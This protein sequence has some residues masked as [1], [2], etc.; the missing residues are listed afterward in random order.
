M[1]DQIKQAV[2]D[3]LNEW[4]VSISSALVGETVRDN[5]WTCDEWRVS[6]SR[7]AH[8]ERLPGT[9][10]FD[11]SY[12]TGTGHRKQVIAMPNPPLNPRCIAYAEWKKTAFKP[13]APSSADILYGLL[14]DSAAADQSFNDWCSEGCYSNDSLKALNT[15]QQCCAITKEL[16][17]IFTR[18]QITELRELLQ[19]Y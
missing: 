18:D 17:K 6:F 3:K 11:T 7:A 1:S 19:D 2:S 5:E 13:V 14:L 9:V 16:R 8:P 15:Y 12:F 10:T 4:N